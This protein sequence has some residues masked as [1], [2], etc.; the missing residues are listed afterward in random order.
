MTVVSVIF[1]VGSF[2]LKVQTEFYKINKQ[3]SK[4]RNTWNNEYNLVLVKKGKYGDYTVV[5]KWTT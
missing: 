1:Q 5:F 2:D 3:H 4:E